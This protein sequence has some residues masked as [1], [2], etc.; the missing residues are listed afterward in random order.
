MPE[1]QAFCLIEVPHA[2]VMP[3]EVAMKLFPLL[4]HGEPVSFDWTNKVY[5]RV[6]PARD[7]SVIKQFSAAQYAQLALESTD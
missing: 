1:P 6:D 5:K 7:G 3:A 2:L 4:C